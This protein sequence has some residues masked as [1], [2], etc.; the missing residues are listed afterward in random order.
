MTRLTGKDCNF[1]EHWKRF[2]RDA[3]EDFSGVE[4]YFLDQV[5]DPGPREEGYPNLRKLEEW[6]MVDMGS[7][8]TLDPYRDVTRKMM[9]LQRP[10]EPKIG[11]FG[12]FSEISL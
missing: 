7:L 1:C 5:D 12:F 2:H 6:W 9:Q 8:G 11:P 3:P 4:I 10:G